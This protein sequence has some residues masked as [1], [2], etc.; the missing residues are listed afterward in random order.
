MAENSLM[1]SHP[2][3]LPPTVAQYDSLMIHSIFETKIVMKHINMHKI[4][5]RRSDD[6]KGGKTVQRKVKFTKQI[7]AKNRI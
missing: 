2:P 1:V 6:M 5:I 3:N 4:I 7:V